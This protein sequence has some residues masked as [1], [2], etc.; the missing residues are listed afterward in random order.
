MGHSGA[1]PWVLNGNGIG[2]LA[3]FNIALE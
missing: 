3:F 2:L 1:G